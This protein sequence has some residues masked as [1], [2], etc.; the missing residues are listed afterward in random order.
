[1]Q[2][3]WLSE[4]RVEDQLLTL[5]VVANSSCCQQLT[6]PFAV[7]GADLRL[8]RS[9]FTAGVQIQHP[10]PVGGSQA[11]SQPG[12]DKDSWPLCQCKPPRAMRCS[13][14]W[15]LREAKHWALIPH[16][17]QLGSG[18]SPILCEMSLLR[19]LV[20]RFLRG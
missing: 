6:H 19:S 20:V 14:R 11:S 5:F 9:M 2:E 18:T 16:P 13:C 3:E 15:L 10:Y 7:R 8:S 17:V 12:C 4:V 1:M